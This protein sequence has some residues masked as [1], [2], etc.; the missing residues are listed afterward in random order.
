MRL[1]HIGGDYVKGTSSNAAVQ[2]HTAEG[3]SAKRN[4]LLV[5]VASGTN[6]TSATNALV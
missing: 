6:Y 4:Y 3:K 5:P 2:V 1:C